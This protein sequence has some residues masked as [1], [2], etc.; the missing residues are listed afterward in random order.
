MTAHDAIRSLMNTYCKAIDQGDFK[1]FGHLFRHARWLVE[2]LSPGP[3]SEGNVRIYEDGTP[4]TKH[5][6]TNVQIDVD[7]TSG[8]A[9]GHSYVTVYQQTQDDPLRVIF[10]GE[11]FDEF[12]QVDGHWRFKQRDIRHPLFGDLSTHLKNPQATFSQAP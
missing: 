6:I 4:R 8:T 10:V 1:T 12:A 3:E 11:Y 2:G 7:T 5:V 9:T